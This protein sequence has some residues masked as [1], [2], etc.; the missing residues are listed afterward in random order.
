MRSH[1]LKE[2]LYFSV[3]AIS[4]F[5]SCVPVTA[6]RPSGEPGPTSVREA[7][8]TGSWGAWW[9]APSSGCT[10]GLNTCASTGSTQQGSDALLRHS[11]DGLLQVRHALDTER[12]TGRPQACLRGTRSAKPLH[13]RRFLVNQL[14]TH[15]RGLGGGVS[16]TRS[17]LIRSEGLTKA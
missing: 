5:H 4:C 13:T 9:R 14:N 6:A 7:S 11:L 2:D 15:L 16:Q 10:V 3:M 17:G 8:R 12:K 1:L